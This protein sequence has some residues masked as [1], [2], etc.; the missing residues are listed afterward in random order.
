MVKM[1]LATKISLHQ[2]E[3]QLNSQPLNFSL[4]KQNFIQEKSRLWH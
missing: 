2:K 1:D 3:S 4:S